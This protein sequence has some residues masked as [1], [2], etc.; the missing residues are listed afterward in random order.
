MGS[1]SSV[2]SLGSGAVNALNLVAIQISCWPTTGYLPSS[3]QEA[4]FVCGVK[5]F[6]QPWSGVGEKGAHLLEWCVGHDK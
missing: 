3:S 1:S 5:E 2:Q 6:E 4:P